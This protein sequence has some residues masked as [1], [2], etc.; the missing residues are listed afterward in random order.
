MKFNPGDIVRI[1][2]YR[3][4]YQILDKDKLYYRLKHIKEDL[5]KSAKGCHLVLFTRDDKLELL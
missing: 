2:G 1:R 3:D 4:K 5:Y